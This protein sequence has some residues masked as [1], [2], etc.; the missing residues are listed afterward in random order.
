MQLESPAFPN[1]GLIPKKYA[2]DG[3]KVNPPLVFLEVPAGTKTL[4]LTMEDPDVPR[5][6]RPDG[7]FDHWIIWN[8]PANIKGIAENSKVPGIIGLNSRGTL[9]YVPP[10]P[11]D[12]EHRYYFRLFALDASFQL[13][14]TTNK[15]DLLKAIEGHVIESAEL[16]GRYDRQK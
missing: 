15:M 10:C 13:S 1:E 12:R 9:E 4:A 2:C 3:E 14:P 8:I 11:P 7:M 6:L 16:M 5:S